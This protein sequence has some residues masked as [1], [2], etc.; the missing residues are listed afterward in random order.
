MR[1]LL[2]CR[3]PMEEGNAAV[4]DGSLGQTIQSVMEDIKPEAAYFTDVD[5]AR[6]AYFIVDIEEASGLPAI[7]E[8]L[9]LGMGA[10]IEAH[11]VMTLEDLQKA[12][13]SL[14]QVARKYS[15]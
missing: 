10:T 4:R 8:P 11:L 14:E 2:K 13:P 7:A 1:F 3:I 15:E 6:G 12:T 5:G 9:F